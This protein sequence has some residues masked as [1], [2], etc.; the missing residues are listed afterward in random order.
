MAELV[1]QKS[2]SL[3]ETDLKY[4]QYRLAPYLVYGNYEWKWSVETGLQVDKTE[5]LSL[6]GDYRF[7]RHR[8]VANV[9]KSLL[10]GT[11]LIFDFAR[12]SQKRD[13]DSLTNP[14]T[15]TARDLTLDSWGIAIEQSL[16]GNSFGSGD[17]ARVQAAESLYKSQALLRSNEIQ[18]LVLQGL[19]LYWDAYVAHE[20]FKESINARDR[21]Q[22]LVGNIKKKNSLGY[23]LPGELNQV[24]AEFEVRE[25]SI[26][27]TFNEQLR[28]METLITYLNLPQT[29]EVEF[30]IPK[31]IPPIPQLSPKMAQETRLLKSQEL[32]IQSVQ[33]ELNYVDSK[34]MPDLNLVAR[35]S[36]TGV[37][38]SSNESLSELTR[39]NHPNAYLGLKLSHF[40]GSDVRR[41]EMLNKKASLEFEKIRQQRNYLEFGDRQK[42]SQRRVEVAYQLLESIKRQKIFRDKA[43]AELNRSYSQGRTDI[44]NL[45]EAM[46]ALNSTELAHSRAI[47]DYFIALNE[48][49]ALRDELIEDEK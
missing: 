32:K 42:Q 9:T 2:L 12:T 1:L 6:I 45:I 35:L 4:E 5:S 22:K 30:E 8:T 16:W 20:N 11:N 40:F 18:N 27:T 37:D 28:L 38:E 17:R 49:S 43:L 24:Q 10:T 39:G 48:W 31:T 26:K 25:Y 29:I 44:R 19:R 15:N 36:A 46:N 34:N 3:K 13:G 21:Y 33:E 14:T 7:E 47:G 23:T 41:E